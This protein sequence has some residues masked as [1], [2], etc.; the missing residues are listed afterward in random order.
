VLA[1]AQPQ[2]TCDTACTKKGKGSQDSSHHGARIKCPPTLSRAALLCLV[3]F[4]T[5]VLPDSSG[6]IVFHVMSLTAGTQV[7]ALRRQTEPHGREPAPSCAYS[8]SHTQSHPVRTKA[9]VGDRSAHA[10]RPATSPAHPVCTPR[11]D[12]LQD[13]MRIFCLLYRSDHVRGDTPPPLH[14]ATQVRASTGEFGARCLGSSLR[15]M[16]MYAPRHALPTTHGNPRPRTVTARPAPPSCR[17]PKA[18]SG[19]QPKMQHSTPTTG[20][21]DPVGWHPA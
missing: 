21:V 17:H 16:R 3:V 7:T 10:S 13:R 6:S 15:H 9:R 11:P 2:R 12:A 20:A 19:A 8:T 5:A 4:E 18:G 14:S 1:A